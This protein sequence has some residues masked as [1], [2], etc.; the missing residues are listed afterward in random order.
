MSE[1][2]PPIEELGI[3]CKHLMGLVKDVRIHEIVIDGGVTFMCHHCYHNEKMYKDID[4]GLM[5]DWVTVCLGCVHNDFKKI[6]KE[7]Y[8]NR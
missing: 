3:A 2:K 4:K 7:V 6:N 8:D 5:D 1:L